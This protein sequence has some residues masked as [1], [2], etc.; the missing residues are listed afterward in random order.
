[1]EPVITISAHK[2]ILQ[3]SLATAL[4][5]ARR[6]FYSPRIEAPVGIEEV[7]KHT[8]LEV[9]TIYNLISKGDIPS[10][11]KGRRQFFLSEIN[12]WIKSGN[13]K[14]TKAI[15]KANADTKL[16]EHHTRY[17]KQSKQL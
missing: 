3:E 7:S 11:K 4:Q 17:S 1:M 9:N 16:K 6:L 13:C 5:E 14:S 10:Y 2:E 15:R 12:E 8:G